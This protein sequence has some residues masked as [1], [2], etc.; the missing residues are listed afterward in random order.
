M[1]VSTTRD[2]PFRLRNPPH[3][4][5]VTNWALRDDPLRSLLAILVGSAAAVTAGVITRSIGTFAFAAFAVTVA[6]WRTWMPIRYEFDARGVTQVLGRRRWLLSWLA[7]GDYEF[8]RRGVLFL[9]RG[10][11]TWWNTTRA[12]FVLWSGKRSEI[13]EI[14]EYYLGARM[15]FEEASNSSPTG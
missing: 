14:V 2:A 6:L 3:D 8:T 10:E 9:P 13:I 12:V 4:V 15:L 11:P 5:R 7:V 1:P